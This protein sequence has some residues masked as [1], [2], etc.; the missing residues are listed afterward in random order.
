M[1][2]IE[3]LYVVCTDYALTPIEAITDLV[4][5]AK[6]MSKCVSPLPVTLLV[7]CYWLG[8]CAGA[9]CKRIM[10]TTGLLE[11]ERA[12]IKTRTSGSC[13]QVMIVANK[14]WNT[15]TVTRCYCR[16]CKEWAKNK[17]PVCNYLNAALSLDLCPV[18]MLQMLQLAAIYGGNRRNEY[19]TKCP[20]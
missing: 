11:N 2:I 19:L 14:L 17:L 6:C 20:F 15:H 9:V 1:R 7:S 12:T 3:S 4:W 13:Q 8:V 16:N 10:W 18:N 5:S